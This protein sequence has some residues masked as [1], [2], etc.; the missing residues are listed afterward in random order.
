MFV[1]G[2]A[3]D[4]EIAEMKKMG[5]DVEN[6]NV[7]NFDLALNPDLDVD[8]SNEDRYEVNGDKLVSVFLDCDIVEELRSIKKTESEK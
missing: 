4:S 3:N 8:Q 1:I 6:V 5:F 2:K 7:L